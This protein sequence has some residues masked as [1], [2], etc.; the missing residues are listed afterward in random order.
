MN[1][2][3]IQKLS[4][5]SAGPASLYAIAAYQGVMLGGFP[6]LGQL[7]LPEF[8]GRAHIGSI[9]GLTQFFTTILGSS[10][11]FIAGFIF[12]RTGSYHASLW[13]IVGTWLL[14]GLATFAVRPHRKPAED[15][16]APA[17]AG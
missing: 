2:T 5:N 12:D 9:S 1:R 6:T 8:F 11:P 15:T 14:C 10:G 7:I 13:I 17:T 16:P 3:R 4:K